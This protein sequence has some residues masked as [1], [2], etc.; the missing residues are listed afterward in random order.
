MGGYPAS[1]TPAVVNGRCYVAGAAGLY[2]L[3]VKDG[4]VIWQAPLAF[5][6]SS[7]LVAGG[8]VYVKSNG[9]EGLTAFDAETG[10]L[11][12]RCDVGGGG[13]FECFNIVQSPILWRAGGKDFVLCLSM[14]GLYCIDP[15][16]GKALWCEKNG[17]TAEGGSTPALSGDTLVVDC[18]ADVKAFKLTPQKAELLWTSKP[19]DHRAGSPL[20]YGGYA[21]VAGEGLL[22]CLD[23]K[24]GE[25]KAASTKM[26]G[27]N[28]TSPVAADGKL[29]Y[30]NGH[31]WYPL[32]V[33]MIS[34]SPDKMEELGVFPNP[35]KGGHGLVCT[36]SSPAL[37][38]GRIYPRMIN[39]VACYDLTEA[40]NK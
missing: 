1:G 12:W 8:A 3:S 37:A 23:L 15:A 21:Y 36:C 19:G 10:R 39:Y 29:F 4:S 7:P 34:A 14:S 13:N 32:F 31:G 28:Y 17:G 2:C 16:T 18:D 20:I 24:T 27:S 5:T 40:G 22:R 33:Q 26:Q 6:N 11:L 9:R 25:R 35:Q 38:N 30:V